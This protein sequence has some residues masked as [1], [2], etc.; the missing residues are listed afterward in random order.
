MSDAIFGG[1]ES[2]VALDVEKDL[3]AIA[4]DSTD[5][6]LKHD[7][8]LYKESSTKWRWELWEHYPISLTAVHVFLFAVFIASPLVNF[9]RTLRNRGSGSKEAEAEDDDDDDEEAA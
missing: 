8:E 4:N 2:V 1:L 7:C 3:M 6:S 5:A 9:L